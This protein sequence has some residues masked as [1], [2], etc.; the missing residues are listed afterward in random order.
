MGHPRPSTPPLFPPRVGRAP[1]HFTRGLA[2]PRTPSPSLAATPGPLVG[3]SSP[4]ARR[5]LPLSLLSGSLAPRVS[6]SFPSSASP[7]QRSCSTTAGIFAPPAPGPACRGFRRPITPPPP[8][9]ATWEQ[10]FGAARVSPPCRLLAAFFG[11]SSTV[12][13]PRWGKDAPRLAFSLGLV[14]LQP[15]GL[16]GAFE[17]PAAAATANLALPEPPRPI[18][19]ASLSLPV[20]AVPRIEAGRVQMRGLRR[21][22]AA[23]AAPNASPP[24]E[25]AGDLSAVRSKPN[26]LD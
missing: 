12:G 24:S 11:R 18:P 14:F 20:L 7:L 22:S 10:S 5:A 19:R 16:T 6:S 2:T 3:A 23:S 17:P 13:L 15:R 9:R 21:A 26:G 4:L 1:A 25:P 8:A